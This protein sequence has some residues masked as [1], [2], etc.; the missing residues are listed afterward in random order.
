MKRLS[1]LLTCAVM[2][3][4]GLF[5]ASPEYVVVWSKSGEQTKFALSDRP[6][7]QF[8]ENTLSLTCAGSRYSFEISEVDKFTFANSDPDSVEELDAVTVKFTLSNEVLELSG[9]VTGADVW[10]YGMD[11]R[12]LACMKAAADGCVTCPVGGLPSGIYLVK[13]ESKTYKISKK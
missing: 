3:V 9:L 11:G 10:L 8:Q 13:T 4:A 5:A 1:M 6:E 12:L 2:A 7:V